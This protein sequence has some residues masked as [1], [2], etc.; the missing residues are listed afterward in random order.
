[1]HSCSVSLAEHGWLKSNST[2]DASVHAGPLPLGMTAEKLVLTRGVLT[3]PAVMAGAAAVEEK[4][5]MGMVLDTDPKCSTT[6]HN[7][8]PW[9]EADALPSATVTS[10]TSP[11]AGVMPPNACATV[12][13]AGASSFSTVALVRN[14][15]GVMK[16]SPLAYAAAKAVGKPCPG[17]SMKV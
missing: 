11:A 10:H 16:V 5:V 8:L 4:N 3:S 7:Q 14:G 13:V 17:R 6:P 2:T 15:T 9:L 12:P 1:L